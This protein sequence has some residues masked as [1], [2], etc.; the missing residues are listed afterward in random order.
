MASLTFPATESTFAGTGGIRLRA[1]SWRAAGAPGSR[2]GTVLLLHGGGQTRYSW[3]AAGRELAAAGWDAL[4]VDARGHGESEWAADGD[5][6]LEAF[7]GDLYAVAAAVPG[8][9]VLVGASLGGMTALVAQGERSELAAALVLVDIVPRVNLSGRERI[10]TFMASAPN[11][12]ADLS[13][14]AEAIHSYNPRRRRPASL[15]GLRKNLRQRGD[16]RWYWHWD[17]RFLRFGDGASWGADAAR[18]RRAAELVT[19][20]TLLIRGSESDIV[21]PAAAQELLGLIPGAVAAEVL[22]GHMVAGDQNDI[23]N[24]ELIA[25]LNERSNM[26]GQVR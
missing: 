14:V 8:P 20:P 1:D 10:R 12:F 21:T 2:R 23:F 11:G 9:L 19:V 15:D 13:D 6:S 7:V 5:Y 26:I 3:H 18:L 16:G 25:F 22:A 24:H 4:A 17:P